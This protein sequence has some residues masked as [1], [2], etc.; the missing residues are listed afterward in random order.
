MCENAFLG[1]ESDLFDRQNERWKEP[2][3]SCGDATRQF[4]PRPDARYSS[5]HLS[6]TFLSDT[7]SQSSI[8]KCK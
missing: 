3:A 8:G 4:H 5:G 6:Q 2:A 1:R 7:A